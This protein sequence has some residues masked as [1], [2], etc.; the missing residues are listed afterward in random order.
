M[1]MM[2]LY[3]VREAGEGEEYVDFNETN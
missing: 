1:K 3:Y 2:T